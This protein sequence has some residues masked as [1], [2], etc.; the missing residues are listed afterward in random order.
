M[1]GTV[2]CACAAFVAWTFRVAQAIRQGSWAPVS[3]VAWLPAVAVA[4]WP[5]PAWAAGHAAVL[6]PAELSRGDEHGARHADAEKPGPGPVGGGDGRRARRLTRSRTSATPHRFRWRLLSPWHVRRQR[7]RRCSMTKDCSRGITRSKWFRR[8]FL[9]V[10]G[11]VILVV[12][13]WRRRRCWWCRAGVPVR[14]AFWLRLV[15]RPSAGCAVTAATRGSPDRPAGDRG[16]RVGP[17]RRADRRLAGGH[18]PGAERAAHRPAPRRRRA[19]LPARRGLVPLARLFLAPPSGLAQRGS[20]C[21]MLSVQRV[22]AGC[23]AGER[24]GA[25]THPPACGSSKVSTVAWSP[26]ARSARRRRLP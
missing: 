14:W 1:A 21:S 22:G 7:S 4:L 23:A 8:S 17:A 19:G 15:A 10:L 5:D 2:R 6:R 9:F 11:L 13:C 3:S 18:R 20:F 16:R 25:G 12:A 24:R 26:R